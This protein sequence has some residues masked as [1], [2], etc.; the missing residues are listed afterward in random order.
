MSLELYC[1]TCR[2]DTEHCIRPST[3]CLVPCVMELACTKCNTYRS[4]RTTNPNNK[5]ECMRLALKAY[6]ATKMFW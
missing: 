3:R 5:D 2:K 6:E 4:F 1:P